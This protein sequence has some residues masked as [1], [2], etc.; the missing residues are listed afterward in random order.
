[1]RDNPAVMSE[2]KIQFSLTREVFSLWASAK[3]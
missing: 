2:I 3:M 1:M